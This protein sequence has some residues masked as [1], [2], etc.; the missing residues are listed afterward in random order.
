MQ[1]EMPIAMQLKCYVWTGT[2]DTIY[3]HSAIIGFLPKA[4]L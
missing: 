4:N 3:A 2:A 1:A